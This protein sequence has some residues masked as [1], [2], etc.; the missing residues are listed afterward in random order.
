MLKFL[1]P[2]VTQISAG[3]SMPIKFKGS[4]FIHYGTLKTPLYFLFSGICMCV[5]VGVNGQGD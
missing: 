5:C 1:K 4:K 3:V 2:A